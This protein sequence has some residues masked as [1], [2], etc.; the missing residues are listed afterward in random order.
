MQPGK[1]DGRG[2]AIASWAVAHAQRLGIRG[3]SYGG[4]VWTRGDGGDGWQTVKSGSGKAAPRTRRRCRSATRTPRRQVPP[5]RPHP[6]EDLFREWRY[7][8]ALSAPRPTRRSVRAGPDAGDQRSTKV[9]EEGAMSSTLPR[10]VVQAALLAAA[11]AAP[12]IMGAS[13][14]HAAELP[15]RRS[16][17][18]PAISQPDLAVPT[19]IADQVGEGLAGSVL[20]PAEDWASAPR[21]DRGL[22]RR[23]GAQQRHAVRGQRDH[24]GHPA[25]PPDQRGGDGGVTTP[26]H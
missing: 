11:G 10:R 16:T 15:V 21:A 25:L 26:L 1:T 9:L 12:L 24:H 13:A 4:K 5:G 19:G 6:N 2:W 23:P 22:L 18:S 14:A 17:A 3:V 20:V 7:S 8:A